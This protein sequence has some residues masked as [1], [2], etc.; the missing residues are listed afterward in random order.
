MERKIK[1]KEI[2]ELGDKLLL[3]NKC[4]LNKSN[5]ELKRKK[6][7]APKIYN[8]PVIIINHISGNLYEIKIAC[9]TDEFYEGFE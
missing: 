3:E 7:K 2:L 5:N 6:N 9:E 4:N 8:I 1:K